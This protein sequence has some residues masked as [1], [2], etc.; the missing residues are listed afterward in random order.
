M[1]LVLT[2]PECDELVEFLASPRCRSETPPTFASG[3]ISIIQIAI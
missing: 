3:S 1:V 2:V